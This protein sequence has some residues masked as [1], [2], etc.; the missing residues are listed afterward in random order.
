MDDGLDGRLML[1]RRTFYYRP[2]SVF[3]TL[4]SL[5]SV[6]S[7]RT[8][9]LIGSRWPTEPGTPGSELVKWHDIDRVTYSHRRRVSGD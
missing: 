2:R 7:I 4:Y 9:Y 8:K 6:G 3:C 1:L 5:L